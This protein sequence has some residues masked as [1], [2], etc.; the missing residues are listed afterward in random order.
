MGSPPDSPPLCFLFRPGE[1]VVVVI[2]KNSVALPRFVA[3]EAAETE[4]EAKARGDGFLEAGEDGRGRV[5]PAVAIAAAACGDGE[6]IIESSA[7]S[8][9]AQV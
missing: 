6:R 3:E 9:A 8:D 5:P 4:S 1:A 2:D 7:A